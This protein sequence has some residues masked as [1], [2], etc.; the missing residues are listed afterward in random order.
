MA[1]TLYRRPLQLHHLRL[2]PTPKNNSPPP[3][4]SGTLGKATLGNK[5]PVLFYPKLS[6]SFP[7]GP[8]PTNP[9]SDCSWAKAHCLPHPLSPTRSTKPLEL[10][11]IDVWGPAHELSIKGN[12]FYLSIVDDYSCFIW[13][14]ALSTKSLVSQTFVNFTTL[15]RNRLST[16]IISV[17][18]DNGTEFKP[19]IPF[20]AKLVITHR[21]TCP[22]SHQQNGS[23][24]TRHRRI[25]DMGLTPLKTTGL[26]LTYWDFAFET[27]T[28]LISRLPTP[29]LNLESPFQK[30]FGVD[31]DYKSLRNFGCLAF[32][33]L[34]PYN[35]YK[36]AF[37]STPTIFIGYSGTSKG[38][39]CYNWATSRYYTSRDVIFHESHFPFA[40]PSSP[41]IASR[42][43]L[44]CNS[45]FVTLSLILNDNI[46]N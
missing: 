19:L 41:L 13:L 12:R 40:P 10:L 37:R 35:R 24:K 2:S 1:F 15:I 8:S 6:L 42:E 21:V 9:C 46:F 23:V 31:P 17:Q 27:S 44:P 11:F 22:Y 45:E 18:S 16:K 33:N 30:L 43:S 7:N 20:F 28:Y 25:V 14:F 36:L 4:T 5:L 38:Y 34:R 3:L 39:I 29:V 26:P 32:P